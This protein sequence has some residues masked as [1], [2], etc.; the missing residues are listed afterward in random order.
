M[1]VDGASVLRGG[2]SAQV[3][4]SIGMVA[5]GPFTCSFNSDLIIDTDVKLITLNK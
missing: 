2:A 5:N 4:L 3:A 1:P